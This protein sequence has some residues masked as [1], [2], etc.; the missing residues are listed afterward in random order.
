MIGLLFA[1]SALSYRNRL[2]ILQIVYSVRQY[3]DFNKAF[4]TFQISQ[5]HVSGV[6]ATHLRP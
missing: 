2:T 5:F 4:F 6:T 1:V 3:S